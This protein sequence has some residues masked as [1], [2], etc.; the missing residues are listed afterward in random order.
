MNHVEFIRKYKNLYCISG[1][2]GDQ[3]DRKE[4]QEIFN[5]Q[6]FDIPPH[7]NSKRVDLPLSLKITKEDFYN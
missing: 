6:G 1:T 3:I 7:N 5:L 2:F 4:M